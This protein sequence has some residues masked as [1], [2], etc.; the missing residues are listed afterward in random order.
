M[1]EFKNTVIYNTDK[2]DFLT[3][4]ECIFSE[5]KDIRRAVKI[6]INMGTKYRLKG[7]LW[8][9]FITYFIAN[10]ENPFSL[11]SE[12]NKKRSESLEF[13]ALN[14]FN[15]FYKLFNFDLKELFNEYKDCIE[16]FDGGKEESSHNKILNILE[17]YFEKSNSSKDML[18]SARKFYSKYGT[19][20]FAFYKAFKLETSGIEPISNTSDIT[21]DDLI[22]YEPQKKELELNTVQFLNGEKANN[23]LLYGE[24]GTGKSSSIKALL[25]KYFPMGLRMVEVTKSNFSG[26][27]TLSSILKNRGYKFIIYLDDLS[28]EEFETDYKF[29]KAVIDGSLEDKPSNVLIYA[30][31]NRRHLVREKISDNYEIDRS[32]DIHRNETAEEKLSLSARFGLAIYYPSLVQAEFFNMSKI[33]AKEAGIKI[34]DET[35]ISEAK[36]WDMRGKGRSGRS[37]SQFINYLKYGNFN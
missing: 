22:G 30:S 7:N 24:S 23:V 15:L 1:I 9:K 8:H 12:K 4:C 3:V 27:N 14:D 32:S 13:A 25:N 26:I 33:L 6:L 35:L 20:M 28:F 11:Y 10:N 19:G 29:L 18:D 34:D 21:F 5:N 31:S 37:A 16:N 36:K 2:T 17:K